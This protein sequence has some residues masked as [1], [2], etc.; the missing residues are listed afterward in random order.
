MKTGISAHPPDGGKTVV[1]FALRLPETPAELSFWYAL[2]D[3]SESE[4]AGFVVLY[5]NPRGSTSYG[6]QFIQLIHHNYPGE[7]YDDLMSGVDAVLGEG[8]V[9]GGQLFV[10]GGSGGGLL[11]AWIIGKTDRFRA[12]VVAVHFQSCYHFG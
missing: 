5:T 1:S 11:S 12:A 4:A 8:Y 2:R 9:D 3:G 10:T 7:D 6:E